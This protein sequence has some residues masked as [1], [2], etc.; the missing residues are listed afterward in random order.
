MG[1][2]LGWSLGG[3]LAAQLSWIPAI[4]AI[5]IYARLVFLILFTV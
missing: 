1:L 4:A 2:W 5:G 3:E